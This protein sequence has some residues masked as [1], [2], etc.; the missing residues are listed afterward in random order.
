MKLSSW[1]TTSSRTTWLPWPRRHGSKPSIS[2]WYAGKSTV[3]PRLR[4]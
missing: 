2:R 4:C 1:S 3:A